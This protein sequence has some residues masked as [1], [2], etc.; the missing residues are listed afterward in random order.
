M[1]FYYLT[2]RIGQKTGESLEFDPTK[3]LISVEKSL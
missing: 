1:C 2:L 3:D